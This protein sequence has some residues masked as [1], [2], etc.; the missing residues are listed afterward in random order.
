MLNFIEF[1]VVF[2]GAL[3][4]KSFARQLLFSTFS[5]VF[6]FGGREKRK[7]NQIKCKNAGGKVSRY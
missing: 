5:F 2:N 7:N 1:A 4:A 3:A 6:P